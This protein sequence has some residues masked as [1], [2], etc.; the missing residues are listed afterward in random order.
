MATRRVAHPSDVDFERGSGVGDGRSTGGGTGVGRLA[1]AVVSRR[2]GDAGTRYP[3]ERRRVDALAPLAHQR[4]NVTSVDVGDFSVNRGESGVAGSVTWNL[5]RRGATPVYASTRG[6]RFFACEVFADGQL[7]AYVVKDRHEAR[8]ALDVTC[9]GGE[10][11]VIHAGR[12]RVHF[13]RVTR[14]PQ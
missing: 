11:G 2:L 4:I 10:N 7:A 8:R 12:L 6:A 1:L 9:H 14:R 13:E 3:G 5:V